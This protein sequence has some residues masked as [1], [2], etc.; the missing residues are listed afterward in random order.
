[1]PRRKHALLTPSHTLS[2]GAEI[3]SQDA[4]RMAKHVQ[5]KY[6]LVCIEWEDSFVGTSGWGETDGARPT[7]AVVRS[8]GC[9]CIT[10]K[11]AN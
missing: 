5:E 10:A 3:L 4:L 2:E 11:T 8:V 6:R 9:W 1:L 7:V